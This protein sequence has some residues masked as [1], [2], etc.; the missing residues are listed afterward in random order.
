MFSSLLLLL[1]S[2][3]WMLIETTSAEL[4]F[5]L[6]VA[7]SGLEDTAEGGMLLPRLTVKPLLGY[8]MLREKEGVKSSR[9]SK[10]IRYVDGRMQ[11][12]FGGLAGLPSGM[13][14]A[15]LRL[16]G[17]VTCSVGLQLLENVLLADI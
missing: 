7:M 12:A 3:A 4:S 17:V 15:F 2:M 5:S 11:G 1:L 14:S 6:W 8:V 10:Q 13:T 9:T 16:V